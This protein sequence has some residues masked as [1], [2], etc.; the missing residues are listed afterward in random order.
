MKIVKKNVYKDW[1]HRFTCTRC[2]SELQAEPDDIRGIY[3]EGWSDSRDGT[4]HPSYWTY[5]V[6][7]AVCQQRHDISSERLPK[8]LQHEVQERR[9]QTQNTRNCDYDR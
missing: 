9:A 5:E 8:I 3:H 1:S 7:C 4:H 2:E 6:I